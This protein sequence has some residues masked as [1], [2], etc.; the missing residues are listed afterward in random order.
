MESNA[1]SAVAWAKDNPDSLLM[2]VSGFTYEHYIRYELDELG[3]DL[4]NVEVDDAKREDPIPEWFRRK[5]NLPQPDLDKVF[6]AHLEIRDCDLDDQ[7]FKSS[8]T[9]EQPQEIEVI[10]NLAEDDT[11][12]NPDTEEQPE[13][14]WNLEAPKEPVAYITVPVYCDWYPGVAKGQMRFK[15]A[16]SMV[17]ITEGEGKDEVEVAHMGGAFAGVYEITFPD[18]KGQLWGYCIKPKDFWEQFE[19]MHNAIKNELTPENAKN[20]V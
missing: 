3:L 4:H 17:K 12:G 13:R 6:D 2:V 1:H 16:D 5:F 14:D 15:L 19:K 8:I 10:K 9:E 7:G 18:G 20:L 11:L